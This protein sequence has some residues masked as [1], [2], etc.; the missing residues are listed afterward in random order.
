MSD[1]TL[2]DLA[3]HRGL[4]AGAGAVDADP[5]AVL[6][7][8]GLT[9]A[10]IAG[11]RQHLAAALQP[12]SIAGYTI[13]ARLGSGAYSNVWKARQE[14]VAREVAIKVM[15]V[16]R[17]EDR[18]RFLEEA[19]VCGGITH[20]NVVTCH[21]A[22]VIGDQVYLVMELILGGDS[23]QASA[24]GLVTPVRALE[25]VRDAARGLS[26][27]WSAGLV[28]RDL[29]PANILLGSTG[30][31]L[32]DFGLSQPNQ[33]LPRSG[34]PVLEGT[35]AF[36]SPEQVAGQLLDVRSDIFSLGGCLYALVTGAKP[37]AGTTLIEV[38]RR[39]TQGPMPDLQAVDDTTRTI[40][41]VAM[42]RDREL[43]YGHPDQLVEDLQSALQGQPPLHARRLRRRAF[44]A[45][46]QRSPATGTALP[47]QVGAV[48]TSNRPGVL[49]LVIAGLGLVV[50]LGIGL[51]GGRALQG[52]AAG[53]R[54]QLE[55][56][57]S[58]TDSAP[59]QEY[60]RLY[61]AGSFRSEADCALAIL[62]ARDQQRA[63]EQSRDAL[64]LA[65][66]QS[67]VNKARADLSRHQ[68]GAGGVVRDNV[69]PGAAMEQ[70][71]P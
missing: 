8:E 66:L 60:E 64:I 50:G 18:E 9:E 69:P 6:R 56:A 3:R 30:A 63:Q 22:G 7:E 51:V 47:D 26:A 12:P 29:K 49:A 39:I 52:P 28:H 65:Q 40:I 10:E 23:E 36:M 48:S 37:F 5:E 67:E 15:P 2:L 70:A 11:L 61:P 24:Q 71:Q 14:S 17:Q 55:L 20:A 35:P 54:A 58:A 68:P 57:R 4:V 46:E 1:A 19:R 62:A 34:R 13:I 32:G 42:A 16:R 53:E 59:W 43:R 27:L 31:K 33:A 44:E 21:E 45:A 41:L 38:L 25:I